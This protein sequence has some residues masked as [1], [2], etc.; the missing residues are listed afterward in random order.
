MSWVPP[1]GEWHG[2]FGRAVFV[3]VDS[4][5]RQEPELPNEVIT[6]IVTQAGDR[7]GALLSRA[8]ACSRWCPK[9]RAR[10]LLATK[11]PGDA[12]VVASRRGMTRAVM[13]VIVDDADADERPS[14]SHI[15]AA[16]NACED[17]R[18]ARW[19]LMRICCAWVA[20]VHRAAYSE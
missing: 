5:M 1:E 20:G 15:Y 12:L 6:D 19:L 16:L 11:T 10:Y 14:L 3:F 9:G 2:K 13:Q 8:L 7:A 4:I 18:T 17:Y